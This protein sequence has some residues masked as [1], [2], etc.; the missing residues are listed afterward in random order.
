MV[1]L[2]CPA[3]ILKCPAVGGG[4]R[5]VCVRACL[6]LLDLVYPG[7]DFIRKLQNPCFSQKLLKISFFSSKSAKVPGAARAP[8][9]P[10]AP[11]SRL[12]PDPIGFGIPRADRWQVLVRHGQRGCS[13]IL[14]ASPSRR[15]LQAWHRCRCPLV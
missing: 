11:F 1:F 8:R 10:Q 6:I 13:A 4:L 7:Q 2:K 14:C 12:G 5:C 9:T 3:V 15:C